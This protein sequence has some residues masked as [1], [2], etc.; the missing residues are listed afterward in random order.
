LAPVKRRESRNSAEFIT[1]PLGSAYV[2]SAAYSVRRHFERELE[3]D[4]DLIATTRPDASERDP[5]ASKHVKHV[6]TRPNTYKREQTRPKM[7]L[8][9]IGLYCGIAFAT[10]VLLF[11]II[12]Y[13]PHKKYFV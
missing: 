11:L 1:K 5:N 6:Q 3:A 9:L 4:K 7:N 12:R 8:G 2:G 10:G 13:F